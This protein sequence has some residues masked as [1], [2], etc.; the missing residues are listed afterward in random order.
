MTPPNLIKRI[1]NF[2]VREAATIKSKRIALGLQK[3]VEMEGASST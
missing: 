2:R 1:D 3:A